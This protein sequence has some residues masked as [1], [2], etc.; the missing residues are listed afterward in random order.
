MQCVGLAVPDKK[1]EFSGFSCQ[2]FYCGIIFIVVIYRYKRYFIEYI[3]M[4]QD[5]F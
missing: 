4:A 2:A 5:I 1:K 3:K